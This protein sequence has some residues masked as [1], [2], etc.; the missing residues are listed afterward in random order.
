MVQYYHT[1]SPTFQHSTLAPMCSK[2]NDLLAPHESD[3]ASQISMGHTSW[4]ESK[5]A[6]FLFW[7]Q[8]PQCSGVV[9]DLQYNEA[10][11]SGSP[12]F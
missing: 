3:N 12:A 10:S 8:R 6:F 7:L 1:S 4:G 5:S 2:W 11:G 9:D